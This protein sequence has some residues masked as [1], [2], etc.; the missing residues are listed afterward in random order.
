MTESSSLASWLLGAAYTGGTIC[1]GALFL[2]YMYQDRLLYFPTIPGASKFT[3]DNPPGYRHP[4][5]FSID[6]EDLMIPCRDGVKINAWL[7]KQ[8]EHTA[9]PTLIFFHG[10][11]GNIGYR[12]PNAVQLFRKLG[13]NILLVDYRGFGHSEGSPSEEGLKIDAE[14]ALDAMYARTDIDTSK[15][16]VFGRSLGGAVSVYLAEKEPSRVAAVVLENTFLSISAMVDALMPFLTYVK[17]L[18]LRM[19]WDSERAIQKLKQPVLFIAGMQDE[20]VPHFH[21]ERLRS[22]ATSSQRVVWYPVPGGT[23]ND[24]WLRGGDKYYSELRGFLDALGGG[25]TCLASDAS[26]DEGATPPAEEN[27]IP[28]MLQQPLLSSLQQKPKAE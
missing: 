21:M 8:K 25:A 9:R 19:D 2:L 4:G 14:A 10:N 18:V 3:K 5:E 17:P 12:L 6:Y 15:L 22:L 11:A 20:L 26:S 13:V 7:M 23:H 16:V 1:V 24:S 28:N 27:A